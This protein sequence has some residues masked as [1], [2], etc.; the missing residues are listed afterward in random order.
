MPHSRWTE[1]TSSN[2][3]LLPRN[4][5][6]Q[7]ANAGL[8]TRKATK[9][10]NEWFETLFVL[11][12]RTRSIGAQWHASRRNGEVA[13]GCS[14][15]SMV[16]ETGWGGGVERRWR[17]L[18]KMKWQCGSVVVGGAVC[19]VQPN[20][21]FLDSVPPRSTKHHVPTGPV[22]WYQICLLGNYKTH[23]F[24]WP[25][26]CHYIFEI[27]IQINSKISQWRLVQKIN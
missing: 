25:T 8:D 26:A 5:H 22:K 27:R 20:S 1:R 4:Q 10:Q 16:N 17:W 2:A 19:R 12:E 13:G 6:D 14:S 3:L 11:L 7:W 24:V 23:T 21:K 15:A 9:A 18:I